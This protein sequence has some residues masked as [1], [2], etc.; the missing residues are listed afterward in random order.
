MHG[1]D[2]ITLSAYFPLA[3]LTLS[4]VQVR[5]KR[6]HLILCEA[7]GEGWHV[8]FASKDGTDDLRICRR[9][10]AG[11]RGATE[12]I[13]EAGRRRLESEIIFLMTVRTAAL[14]QM[15]ACGLLRSERRLRVAS[16]EGENESEAEEGL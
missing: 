5:K 1:V 6:I 16:G 14:K 8:A 2:V 10:A 4:F 9:C 11:K 7:A 15:P 3:G 13:A 12:D